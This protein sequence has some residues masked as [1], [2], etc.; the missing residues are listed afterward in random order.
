MQRSSVENQINEIAAEEVQNG[1]HQGMKQ[2]ASIWRLVA[3]SI[4]QGWL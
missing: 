1:R 3:W 2:T 4:L